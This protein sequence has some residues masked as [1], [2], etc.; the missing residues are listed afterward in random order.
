MRLVAVFSL[1][2]LSI[3]TA[4]YSHGT[5]EQRRACTRDAVTLCFDAI[6]DGFC[7]RGNDTASRMTWGDVVAATARLSY[8]HFLRMS[9]L[10]HERPF[11]LTWQT[12]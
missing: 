8:P 10:R 9:A 4:A 6:P 11:R 5:A 1:S 12:V 7:G 2:V 3:A